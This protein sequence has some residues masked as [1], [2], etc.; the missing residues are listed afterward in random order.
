MKYFIYHVYGVKIGCTNDTMRRIEIEQGYDK[1]EYRILEFHTN[2]YEAS[3]RE[4]ELQSIYGYKQD[5]DPYHKVFFKNK[6]GRVY[7]PFNN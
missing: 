2:I 3:K 4:R 5:R 7:M 1:S 6:Y